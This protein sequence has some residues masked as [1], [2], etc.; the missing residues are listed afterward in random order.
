MTWLYDFRSLVL[1]PGE[2]EAFIPPCDIKI[3]NVALGD[4]LE[5]ETGRTTLKLTYTHPSPE[6]DSE[7][8]EEDKDEESDDE[9]EPITTVLCSLTP[10]KVHCSTIGTCP[11]TLLNHICCRLSRLLSSSF[12]R[13]TK[14]SSLRLSA[15]SMFVFFVQLMVALS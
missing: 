8:D 6:N 1:I 5:D 13:V 3:T 7:S 15:K 11:R 9:N 14:K 4:E 2:P 12:W 10:G